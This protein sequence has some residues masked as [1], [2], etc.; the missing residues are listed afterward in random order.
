MANT[1]DQHR[2]PQSGHPARHGLHRSA[3]ERAEDDRTGRA[4]DG[5]RGPAYR[6]LRSR[7]RRRGAAFIA[8]SA[9]SA[10]NP[11]HLARPRP[12]PASGPRQHDDLTRS[13]SKETSPWGCVALPPAR[14]V[15]GGLDLHV[16]A[17]NGV[18]DHLPRSPA[19]LRSA[20]SPVTRAS[21]ETTG[22]SL[23]AVTSAVSS[24]NARSASRGSGA[25]PRGGARPPPPPRA[26]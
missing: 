8:A 9:R 10:P 16:L 7:S 17:P 25:G 26:A 3:S 12:M 6:R 14:L 1:L 13:G 5:E 21:F 19:R 23:V 18:A 15:L 4:G 20:T 11:A 24:R 22:R 2:L